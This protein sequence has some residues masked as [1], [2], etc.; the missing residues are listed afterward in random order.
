MGIPR[1]IHVTEACTR[2]SLKAGSHDPFF[3]SITFLSLF[4]LIEM[5]TRITNFFEFE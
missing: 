3:Y 5:L 1:L 4:Q 2:T